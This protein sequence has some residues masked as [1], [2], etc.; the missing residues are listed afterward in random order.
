V[1][2]SVIEAINLA[3]KYKSNNI[4]FL[5][6]GF[7]T[8]APGNAYGVL[9]AV[10][11]S[12]GNFYILSAQKIMP[13]AMRAVVTGGTPVNGFICPGHVSAITGTGIYGFLPREFGIGCV[14]SGFEPVDILLTVLM[15]IRQVN[16]DAPE[17]EN[18]YGRA[19]SPDGNTR[20][21]KV[22][23]RVYMVRDEWWRGFGVIP[24]S[25]L[26]LQPGFERFDAG[27][28]FPLN[29]VQPSDDKTCICGEILRGAR[30][31][32][33]CPLFG[34]GCTPDDPAGACMVSDEGACLA[35]FKYNRAS[36]AGK[37]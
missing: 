5:A 13:P 12:L 25:G 15:L 18:E 27:K 23:D 8:T 21:L 29:N 9:E 16:R 26:Q 1:I 2:Y 10:A 19:V 22:M 3:E 24:E 33:E 28:A 32:A 20:A 14:I 11:R 6:I 7:E 4:V 35:F 30:S 17:V 31:P 36:D 37:R 34:T